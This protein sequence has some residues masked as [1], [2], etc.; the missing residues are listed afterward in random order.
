MSM[1]LI[2]TTWIIMISADEDQKT[3]GL[4]TFGIQEHTFVPTQLTSYVRLVNLIK[5]YSKCQYLTFD[6]E[7]ISP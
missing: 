4:L 5:N 2:K 6:V 1:N 3:R 7:V